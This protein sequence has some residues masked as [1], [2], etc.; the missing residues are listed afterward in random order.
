[1]T[2]APKPAAPVDAQLRPREELLALID[3]VVSKAMSRPSS[4]SIRELF[5]PLSEAAERIRADASLREEIKRLRVSSVSPAVDDGVKELGVL[6]AHLEQRSNACFENEK[7]ASVETLVRL[8][9]KRTTYGHAAEMV[10]ASIERLLSLG[11]RKCLTPGAVY[12]TQVY[13]GYLQESGLA[14]AQVRVSVIFPEGKIWPFG[15]LRGG[16]SEELA[17]DKIRDRVHEALEPVLATVLY[18]E[19]ALA[20]EQS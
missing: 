6:K 17:S 19:N 4:V 12:A 14:E 15:M 13:L 8:Q 16:F 10:T 1:M 3:G 5:S 18:T 2:D 11:E 7:E 20:K 9:A